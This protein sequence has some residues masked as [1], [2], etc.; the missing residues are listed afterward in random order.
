MWRPAPDGTIAAM[1]PQRSRWPLPALVLA[2]FLLLLAPAA[3]ADSIVY[4]AR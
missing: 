2:A 1:L 4:T 3:R